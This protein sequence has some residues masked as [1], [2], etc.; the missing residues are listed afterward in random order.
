MAMRHDEKG[1]F[2]AGWDGDAFEW[3]L[4]T[5]QIVRNYTAHPSQLVAIAVRPLESD[6][7]GIEPWVGQTRANIMPFATGDGQEDVKDVTMPTPEPT[8][9]PFQQVKEEHLLPSEQMLQLEQQG[10]D[11]DVRS[12]TSFDPLFDDPEGESMEEPTSRLELAVQPTQ[13]SMPARA[14]SQPA[15]PTGRQ[16]TGTGVT[17]PAPKNAPPVL[18]SLSYTMFSPDV[19]M[20]ASIDGQVMLWD[21]RVQTHGRGVGRLWMSEKTPPWCVSA[22]WSADGSQIYAG[23]RNGA[24][25]VWDVRQTGQTFMGTPRILKVIRN[26]PSSGVVSC[27]VAFPDGRHIACASTDNIR[28]W[29]VAEAGEPDA[30]TG[31][32]KS[33]VQFKI[34]PGHHGGT[35]SQLL[36]DKQ[37]RFLVSASSNRGWF[38]ESSK[39]VFVHDVKKNW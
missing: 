18:D 2:S 13:L 5:G 22:C 36:V 10:G 30:I 19:L 1:F 4:N 34:I 39:T 35:I 24:V 9:H 27:I 11:E 15:L 33:G 16:A 8:Q 7:T 32:M 37:G 12:D 3:D 6:Y 14:A 20:T 26:P 21:R 23:R 17:A 28:L 29:N 38:G 31:R 25:D